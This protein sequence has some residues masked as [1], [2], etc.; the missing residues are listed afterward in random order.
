MLTAQSV[1]PE[2]NSQQPSAVSRV[3]H[4]TVS[5]M[6]CQEIMSR[7]KTAPVSAM[8]KNITEEVSSPRA[9]SALTK[10][11]ETPLRAAPINPQNKQNISSTAAKLR[12]LRSA[13]P[14]RNI[15]SGSSSKIQPLTLNIKLFSASGTARKSRYSATLVN[16]QATAAESP[17]PIPIKAN[18]RT[19]MRFS[20]F[21]V[22]LFINNNA[23]MI[24]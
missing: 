18:R 12:F 15:T 9:T 7:R 14:A 23:L 20:S 1:K 10:T 6:Q 8:A 2:G 11:S 21:L 22:R 17:A 5:K 16:R 13:G 4:T 19:T 24:T 3:P